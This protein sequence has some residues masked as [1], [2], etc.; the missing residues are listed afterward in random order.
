MVILIIGGSGSGKSACAERF[1]QQ[2][3]DVKNRYYLATM[4]AFDE[5]TLKRIERHRKQRRG[6]GF[7]TLEQP[8]D[9]G[10]ALLRM[11]AEENAALLECMSNLMA[12]EMFGERNL[13]ARETTEKILEGV[14]RLEAGVRHLVIVTNNVFEDGIRYDGSTMEYMRALA[15]INRALF[16]D[17]DRAVEVTAGLPSVMKKERDEG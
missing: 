1:L 8:R 9:I 6:K 12:N 5:E 15:D 16:K 4:Q 13:C 2:L 7:L 14:R 3:P 10:Q 17:A 11:R